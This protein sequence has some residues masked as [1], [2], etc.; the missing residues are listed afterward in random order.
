MSRR[1][2]SIRRRKQYWVSVYYFFQIRREL[3]VELNILLLL[4]LTR[5]RNAVKKYTLGRVSPPAVVVTI[6]KA[7][8]VRN[9]P[10][11]DIPLV[12]AGEPISRPPVSPL[13]R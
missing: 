9:I 2:L 6:S 5:G 8:K 3:A 1:R 7:P 13:M 11:R 4:F 12:T 10:T